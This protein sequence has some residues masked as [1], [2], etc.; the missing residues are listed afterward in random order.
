MQITKVIIV[1]DI[2]VR[3]PVN[4]KICNKTKRVRANVNMYNIYDTQCDVYHMIF[5]VSTSLETIAEVRANMYSLHRI[6]NVT[7]LNMKQETCGYIP[8]RTLYFPSYIDIYYKV[9]AYYITPCN[10]NK[11]SGKLFGNRAPCAFL[12]NGFSWT[13]SVN[14]ASD[15]P[16]CRRNPHWFFWVY[17]PCICIVMIWKMQS[18]I[19]CYVC[20]KS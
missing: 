10:L 17:S 12:Y 3:I 9:L 16:S 6:L 2:Y 20:S 15:S 8:K 4:I 14:R 19:L 5:M 11:F 7:R 18:S 13:F 1:M